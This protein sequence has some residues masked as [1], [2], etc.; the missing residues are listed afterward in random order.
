MSSISLHLFSYEIVKHYV[1]QY[2]NEH[3]WTD[4]NLIDFCFLILRILFAIGRETVSPVKPVN[5]VNAFSPRMFYPRNA[6]RERK[7]EI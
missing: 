6:F 5:T 7:F 4:E 2:M 3:T 1:A